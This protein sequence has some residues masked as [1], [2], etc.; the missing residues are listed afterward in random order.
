MVAGP[1]IGAHPGVDLLVA[2][3][4][5]SRLQVVEKNSWLVRRIAGAY[6]YVS[7][8]FCLI[9]AD[10]G[11]KAVVIVLGS[12]TVARLPAGSDTGCRATWSLP[13]SG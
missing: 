13:A 9:G 7:A 4:R 11:L 6:V 1:G 12:R 8:A 10:M 3:D 5:R 2:A